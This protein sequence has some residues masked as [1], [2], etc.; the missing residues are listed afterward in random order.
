MPC[1]KR[2]DYLSILNDREM[3]KEDTG[4]DFEGDK[5]VKEYCS[6]D[7]GKSLQAEEL[8]LRRIVFF[9]Q[10]KNARCKAR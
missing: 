10:K 2:H 6:H 4:I 3:G 7:L 9:V 5:P 8:C 1:L